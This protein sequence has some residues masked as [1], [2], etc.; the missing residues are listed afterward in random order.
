MH[1]QAWCS[2]CIERYGE[3]RQR[4]TSA[5]EQRNSSEFPLLAIHKCLQAKYSFALATTIALRVCTSRCT[6]RS[7][8]WIRNWAYLCDGPKLTVGTDYFA[9]DG[10]PLPVVG[11]TYM[12]SDVNRLYLAELNAFV[13]DQ[14]MKQIYEAGLNSDLV[15]VGHGC[16]HVPYLFKA[17]CSLSKKPRQK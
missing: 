3:E 6:Y 8:F 13:W 7:G 4:E 11:T 9:L 12:A 14:D 1:L 15:I 10:K 2:K 16:I 17:T 5:V